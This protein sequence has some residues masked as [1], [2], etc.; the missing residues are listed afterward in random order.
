VAVVKVNE[1]ESTLAQLVDRIENGEEVVIERGGKPI[2]RVIA[3]H[4]PPRKGRRTL[5]QWKGRV[6]MSDDF[7][8]PLPEVELAAWYGDRE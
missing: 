7:D 6:R 1:T 5:G 8:A 3:I 4:D 2:A